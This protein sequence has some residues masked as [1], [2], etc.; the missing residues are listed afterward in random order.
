[1]TLSELHQDS[2]GVLAVEA[3]ARFDGGSEKAAFLS[4]GALLSDQQVTFVGVEKEHPTDRQED[5]EYVE[6]EKSEG[7]SRGMAKL[8]LALG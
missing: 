6:R 3:I 8:H 5:E 7:N 1:M 4:H 2:L